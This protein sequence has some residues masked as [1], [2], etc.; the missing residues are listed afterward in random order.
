MFAG[1][2]FGQALATIPG[3]PFFSTLPPVLLAMTAA[4]GMLA[5]YLMPD[6]IP[7]PVCRT[8]HSSIAYTGTRMCRHDARTH[9]HACWRMQC[10]CIRQLLSISPQL[11]KHACLLRGWKWRLRTRPRHCE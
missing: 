11:P 9:M 6:S 7:H 4:A 10:E 8:F 1:T 3:I 2:A 5:Q